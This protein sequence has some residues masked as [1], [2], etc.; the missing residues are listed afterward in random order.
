MVMPRSTVGGEGLGL[1]RLLALP[2]RQVPGLLWALHGPRHCPP[3]GDA[4]GGEGTG[5][6]QGNPGGYEPREGKVMA[7]GLPPSV[8]RG[9]GTGQRWSSRCGVV[10]RGR[11]CPGTRCGHSLS[12]AATASGGLSGPS[13]WGGGWRGAFEGPSEEERGEGGSPKTPQK[14]CHSGAAEDGGG[15]EGPPRPC[16]KNG[17]KVLYFPED[18]GGGIGAGGGHGP[19]EEGRTASS[20]LPPSLPPLRP[21]VRFCSLKPRACHERACSHAA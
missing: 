7:S 5:G 12:Q 14:C 8:H 10:G 18:P 21:G 19:P 9:P 20:P 6:M 11:C 4:G 13:H 17:H 15:R 3:P 16:Q 1:H 2:L